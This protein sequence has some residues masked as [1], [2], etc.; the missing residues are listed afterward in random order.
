MPVNIDTNPFPLG[1]IHPTPGTPVSILQNYPD[2]DEELY[3]CNLIL[4]QSDSQ[5]I[6]RCFIGNTRLNTATRE[7]LFYTLMAPGDT[8]VLSKSTWK[9]LG[10]VVRWTSTS[11]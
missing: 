8:F 3:S 7:G 4:V 10:T 11:G 9:F 1:F 5:N 6:G 2:L